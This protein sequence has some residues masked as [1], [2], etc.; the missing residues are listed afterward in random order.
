M[1]HRMTPTLAAAAVAAGVLAAPAL[2]AINPK[3]GTTINVQGLSI[4][5]LKTG[6]STSKAQQLLGKPSSQQ[7]KGLSTVLNYTKV[8]LQ[9]TFTRGTQGGSAKLTAIR[10]TSPSFKTS[11][12]AI[13]IGSTQTALKNA[14]SNAHC[15]T[16][17]SPYCVVQSGKKQVTFIVSKGKI[18]RIQLG[19]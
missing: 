13:R 4:G 1:V 8:G 14:Y 18:S 16:S 19:S 7:H 12:G 15:F 3:V 9:L 5:A 11:K 2:A 10:V 6:I 17:G